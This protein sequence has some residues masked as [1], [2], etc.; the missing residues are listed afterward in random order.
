MLLICLKEFHSHSK[1][2]GQKGTLCRLVRISK[3][4]CASPESKKNHNKKILSSFII[5]LATSA[6]K[7]QKAAENFRI[8][9]F[10]ESPHDLSKVTKKQQKYHQSKNLKYIVILCIL[11]NHKVNNKQLKNR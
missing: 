3:N 1:P 2:R 7:L 8:H 11:H 4:S 6:V 10:P 5:E 9:P